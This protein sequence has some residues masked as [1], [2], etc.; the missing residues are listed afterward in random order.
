MNKHHPGNS[1][2]CS[3]M[4]PGPDA[5]P[6]SLTQTLSCSAA[7]ARLSF[8]CQ[9]AI[10]LLQIGCSR[11]EVRSPGF[12]EGSSVP[13]RNFFGTLGYFPIVIIISRRTRCDDTCSPLGKVE[14]TETAGHQ[15]ICSCSDPT[16][17][18]D[19]AAYSP[20]SCVGFKDATHMT[21]GQPV[22]R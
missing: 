15:I 12:K 3:R 11:A 19:P 8:A 6:P 7:F 16:A 10:A 4:T 20:P 9:L 5:P 2:A 22:L 17:R 14:A 18:F 1:L 21:K 13:G